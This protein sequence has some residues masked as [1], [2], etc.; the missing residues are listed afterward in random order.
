MQSSKIARK[1]KVKETSNP[2]S[3]VFKDTSLD[4][5][6]P[7]SSTIKK[8]QKECVEVSKNLEGPAEDSKDLVKPKDVDVEVGEKPREVSIKDVKPESDK[9]VVSTEKA[10]VEE[11]KKEEG[12]EVIELIEEQPKMEAKSKI[13]LDEM[14]ESKKTAKNEVQKIEEVEKGDKLEQK[15]SDANESKNSKSTTTKIEI[16]ASKTS[17]TKE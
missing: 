11:S 2:E 13:D 4:P 5:S 3:V 12:V 17:K 1:K 15:P 14:K 10:N 16:D 8:N 7:T 9:D 6:K